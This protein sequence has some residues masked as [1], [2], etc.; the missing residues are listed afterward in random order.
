MKS[1]EERMAVLLNP[2]LDEAVLTEQKLFEAV[3]SADAILEA[4]GLE[5]SAEDLN[6]YIEGL[7]DVLENYELSDEDRLALEGAFDSLV[8]GAAW[9][10]GKAGKAV[11]TYHKAKTAWANA[12]DHVKGAYAKGHEAGS[13]IDP[14][15]SMARNW[16]KVPAKP[17]D[18]SKPGLIARGL[19]KAKAWVTKKKEPKPESDTDANIRKA[20][21]ALKAQQA[22]WQAKKAAA[23]KPAEPAAKPAEPA[24]AAEKPAE[25]P[26]EPAAA[27]EPA[28]AKPEKKRKHPVKDEPASAE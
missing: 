12:K 5:L 16:D 14:E 25:K 9:A 20:S 3:D 28:T 24:A 23:A 11:G 7:Q 13:A 2:E 6:S 21:E 15:G 17:K 4:N 27:A 22:A 18:A 10:A 8:R 1:I 26:A 19:A